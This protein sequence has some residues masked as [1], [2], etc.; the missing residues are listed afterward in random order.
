MRGPLSGDNGEVDDE[1]LPGGV[2]NAGAVRRV[3]PHVVRPANPHSGS[4]HCFLVSLRA[5][6]FDGVPLAVALDG[7]CE[8][9]EFIE[10]DVA[11]PP[12]PAWVQSDVAL[13]SVAQLLRRFHDASG[14]FDPG[15][16]SWSDELADPAGGTMVCHND[17]CLENVVFRDG[18]AVALLDFDFA[19][20]GRP[21]YDLAQF[22]RMCVPA[23][24][25]DNAAQ[26][27]WLPADRPARLRLVADTYGLDAPAARSSSPCSTPT[28]P[29]AV[30]S[31]A[32]ASRPAT[33]TSS[34]CG[35]TSA[36]RSHST[37]GG[38]G[39]PIT[40]RGLLVR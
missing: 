8:R 15:G 37:G 22:A 21:V 32:A 35:T 30:S 11:V 9:L 2:A 36:A 33:R 27:G 16:L 12:Y 24:D 18:V 34:R 19:A 1:E 23:E 38:A 29:A 31:S 10:G 14:H 40:A 20:P 17:V 7:A 28:S 4:V 13:A 6:G 26:P 25:D 39:G 5:A 3:G